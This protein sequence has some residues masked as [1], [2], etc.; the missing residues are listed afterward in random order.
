[1]AE[2]KKTPQRKFQNESSKEESPKNKNCLGEENQEKEYFSLKEVAA[3]SGVSY[4]TVK[5][6]IDHGVLAAYH[7]GRK[8]FVAKDQALA[9][10][11]QHQHAQGAEG[12]TIQQIMAKIPLSYAFLVELV[13]T[14]KLEAIKVGRQ[15]IIPYDVFDAFMEQNKLEQK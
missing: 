5:R 11:Q 3:M 8:Y 15:Y 2:K 9:Y 6:D 12:Y 14:K 4:G 10:G 7:I 1:M 13:K